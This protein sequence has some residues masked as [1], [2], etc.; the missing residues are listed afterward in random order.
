MRSF[1]LNIFIDRPRNEV[2]DHLTE[3]INM[4]GLQPYLTT[5]DILKEQKDS[6]GVALRPF[7][8]LETYRWLGLPIFKSRVY[9][10]I[11]L[12]NPKREFVIRQYG[13]PGVQIAYQYELHEIEEGRTHLVQKA[14]F[15]KVNRLFERSV[16]NRANTAQRGLLTNLKVRLEKP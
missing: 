6:G 16:Y 1:E 15:E 12:T 5:I 10:V 13:K 2:Y 7:Y 8:M 9:I 14:V 3:P 11:H 4:I